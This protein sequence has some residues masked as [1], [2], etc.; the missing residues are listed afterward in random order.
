MPVQE[1][2]GKYDVE[3]KLFL[4]RL[5]GIRQQQM[6]PVNITI[7]IMPDICIKKQPGFIKKTISL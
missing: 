5:P 4:I 6:K 3:K 1:P 7:M 2:V